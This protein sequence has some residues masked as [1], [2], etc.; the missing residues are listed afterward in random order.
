MPRF[1][2]LVAV[3]NTEQLLPQCLDSLL[4]Q[5]EPSLEVICIDDCSTDRSADVIRDYAARD[6][7][8][9]YLRTDSNSGQAV[10][11]NLGLQ[12]AHGTLTTMVDADDW[13]EHDCLELMWEAFCT[14]PDID[15][16]V[17]RLVYWQ[18]GQQWE[19]ERSTRLPHIMTGREACH[20]SID[21]TLHGYYAIRTELHRQY[22][23]DTSCRLYSDDN[24]SRQHFHHCRHVAMSRGTYYYRQHPAN[25]TRQLT[26]R[27]FDFVP[28]NDS[29]RA[30]LEREGVDAASLS[31]CEDY[32]WRNYVGL[33]REW[34]GPCTLSEQEQTEVAELFRSAFRA[35]KPQRLPRHTRRTPAFIPWPSYRLFTLWQRLLM[36]RRSHNPQTRFWKIWR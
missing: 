27:R 12:Q 19:H 6:S 26:R 31:L 24:T 25:S 15:A 13:L 1:S 8:V 29:L 30:M 14:Q 11:R 32:V 7:R 35:M 36:L 22:P 5:T 23:Y 2:I 34:H 20:Y 18:E 21:W 17:H 28:A 16:V 33:W 10:A 9:K 3:F 4:S